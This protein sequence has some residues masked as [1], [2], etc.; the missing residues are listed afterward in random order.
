MNNPVAIN[1]AEPL[2]TDLSLLQN[3]DSQ[4]YEIALE[5]AA[6]SARVVQNSGP[7]FPAVS[8]RNPFR[9]PLTHN[10]NRDSGERVQTGS[11]RTQL[12]SCKNGRTAV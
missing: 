4:G 5:A 7:T 2:S 1:S 3:R 8:R 10:G 6:E 9:V 11:K 12:F